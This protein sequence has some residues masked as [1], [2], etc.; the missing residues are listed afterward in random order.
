MDVIIVCHTEFGRV[1][2]SKKLAFVKDPMG[3]SDGTANLVRVTSHYGAKV[4][5]AV[6]PEVVPYFRLFDDCEVGL[7]IH[8]GW[9]EFTVDGVSYYVGDTYLRKYCKQSSDKTVLRA[10]PFEEQSRMIE[11]AK[12]YIWGRFGVVP[13]TFVAGRW[14][15][16]N[17]TVKALLANGMTRDC[18][19]MA[20]HKESHYDWSKLP[21]M[22][23][24]YSPSE[25]DYQK[26]GNLPLLMLPISQ[27][28]IGGSVNPEV[29]RIYS[30]GALKV[31][32]LEYYIKKARLFHIC[33]HSACMTDKFYISV[34]DRFL[35]FIAKHAVEFKLASEI[36][37]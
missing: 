10:F 17:D 9:E 21:R 22:A 33:L 1:L 26:A 13:R 15:I 16:N 32:F 34:M 31:A 3:V 2:P 27:M 18:S 36:T 37:A 14:G 7:H 23:K 6:C 11:T 29:A 19:A 8:P 20:S 28:V 5:F 35:A 24:P 25:R 4:T 12:H 30:L